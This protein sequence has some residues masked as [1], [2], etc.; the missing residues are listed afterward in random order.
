MI[1]ADERW[2]IRMKDRGPDKQARLTLLTQPD[3]SLRLWLSGDWTRHFPLP[4]RQPI[5]QAL[6]ATPAVRTLYFD[7]HDLGHWDSLLVL[8]V[9][10]VQDLARQVGAKVVADGLPPGVQ[11]LLALRSADA[12]AEAGKNA[13]PTNVGL[14]ARVGQSA[15]DGWR[16]AVAL[17]AFGGELVL[18]GIRV[19]RGRGSFRASDLWRFI[20]HSGV[21]ALPIISYSGKLTTP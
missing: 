4:S 17:L 8:F 11:R 12:G 19:L 6:V 3:G 5:Q 9:V 18:A 15:A 1:R 16:N 20:Q 21:D 2:G 13:L 7:T 14:L 10:E